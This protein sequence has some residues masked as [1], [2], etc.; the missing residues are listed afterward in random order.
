[1]KHINNIIIGPIV[2]EK[3][4]RLQESGYYT[5]WVQ[6]EASKFQISVA[7]SQIFGLT[8]LSLNTSRQIG[9]LKTDWKKRTPIQ[10]NDRKKA[11]IFVGKDKK[12]ELI[13]LNQK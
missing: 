13:K 3:S 1:M 11:I 2:S 6:K 4:L 12:I 9:K 5:F 7:F 8:P 10:K